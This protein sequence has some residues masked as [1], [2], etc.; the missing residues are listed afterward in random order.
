MRR[1]HARPASRRGARTPRVRPTAAALPLR[2]ARLLAA[3]DVAVVVDAG[4]DRL[5]VDLDLEGAVGAAAAGEPR[6]AVEAGGDAVLDRVGAGLDGGDLPAELPGLAG[7]EAAERPGVGGRRVAAGGAVVDDPD[8]ALGVRQ[9]GVV[10]ALAEGGGAARRAC[11]DRSRPSPRRSA[12]PWCRRCARGSTSS[13]SRRSTGTA[14]NSRGGDLE[15]VV[16]LR[17]VV[18]LARRSAAARGEQDRR[19]RCRGQP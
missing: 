19:E 10:D 18:V 4:G 5:V 8:R 15:P 14:G 11:R 7:L 1:E 12:R 6:A 3:D 13:R 16:A 17:L 2:R 9:P